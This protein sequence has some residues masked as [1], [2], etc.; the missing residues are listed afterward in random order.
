MRVIRQNG[1]KDDDDGF[2]CHAYMSACFK[3]Y[4]CEYLTVCMYVHH[5]QAWCLGRPGKGI[6]SLEL[7]LSL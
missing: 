6:S 2:V 7:E 5:M 1:V 3:F 4:V